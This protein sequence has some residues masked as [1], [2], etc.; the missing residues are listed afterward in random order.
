MLLDQLGKIRGSLLSVFRTFDIFSKIISSW[1]V[2][3]SFEHKPY[4]AEDLE[5]SPSAKMTL[6]RQGVT[7]QHTAAP[8]R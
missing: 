4:Q 5:G 8:A 6:D 3:V 2:K 7:I 1:R